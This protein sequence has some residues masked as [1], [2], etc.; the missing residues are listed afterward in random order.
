MKYTNTIFRTESNFSLN[1]MS[2]NTDN[3]EISNELN[4]EDDPLEDINV[5]SDG[6]SLARK[7][8]KTSTPKKQK[9]NFEEDFLAAIRETSIE[10]IEEV[11]FFESLLPTLLSL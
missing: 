7:R 10:E 4:G 3:E 8:K 6:D 2:G 5:T 9:N 11:S 1:Q